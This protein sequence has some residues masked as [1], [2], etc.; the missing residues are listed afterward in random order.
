VEAIAHDDECAKVTV[1]AVTDPPRVKNVATTVVVRCGPC[2]C[3]HPDR[4]PPVVALVELVSVGPVDPASRPSNEHAADMVMGR[5]GKK[6]KQ[7]GGDTS[8]GHLNG[9]YPEGFS[10]RLQR[11]CR[12][13]K[14]LLQFSESEARRWA[15][16][17]RL[18]VYC[19]PGRGLVR[20]LPE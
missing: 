8:K 1:R 15:K 9:Y 5:S 18:E 11:R 20:S 17:G 12:V 10:G 16:L 2:G 3:R 7:L 4:R 13:C 14:T 6:A 19:L